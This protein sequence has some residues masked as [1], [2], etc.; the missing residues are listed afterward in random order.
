MVWRGRLMKWG[1]YKAL[2]NG[3]KDDKVQ[4][5]M[6]TIQDEEQEDALRRY[7]T[8]KYEVVRCLMISLVDAREFVG[9]TFRFR[10]EEKHLLRALEEPT[11]SS[12][13]SSRPSSTDSSIDILSD[14]STDSS[15]QESC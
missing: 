3:S 4:G 6:Y 8:A 9:L 2:V 13:D 7:E 11:E 14:S 15:S 10:E 12:A 5:F 1:R